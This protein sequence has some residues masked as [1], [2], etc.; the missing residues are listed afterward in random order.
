MPWAV[1]LGLIDSAFVTPLVDAGSWAVVR[2]GA[3]GISVDWEGTPRLVVVRSR[4]P[5]GAP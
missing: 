5:G 2:R 4:S 1:N 3:V